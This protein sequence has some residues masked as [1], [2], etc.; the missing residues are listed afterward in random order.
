MHGLAGTMARVEV[1]VLQM[2][3]LVYD[4]RLPPPLTDPDAKLGSGMGDVLFLNVGDVPGFVLVIWRT[5]CINMLTN[6]WPQDSQ[7]R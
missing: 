2:H 4:A 6:A 5:K 1:T 7:G 3:P